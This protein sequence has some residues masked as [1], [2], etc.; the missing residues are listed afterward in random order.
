MEVLTSETK[1]YMVTELCA[2]GEAFDF[3]TKNGK[4]DSSLPQSKK[5]M[6]Q[7]VDAVS[8]CHENSVVHRFVK[9]IHDQY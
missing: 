7:I 9:V 2:R 3:I 5:I 1:I 8:Y 4:L 6:R